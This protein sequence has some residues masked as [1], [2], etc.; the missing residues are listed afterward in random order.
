[1]RL[2]KKETKSGRKFYFCFVDFENAVN[3]TVAKDTLQG[4]RFSKNDK[5]GLKISFAHNP[6]HKKG[7]K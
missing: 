1:V 5:K 3:A 4:Y 2:I 7:S 6:E